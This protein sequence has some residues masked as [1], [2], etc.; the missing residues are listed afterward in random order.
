MLL[1]SKLQAPTGT[2]LRSLVRG[3]L[4]THQTE[5]SSPPT[6]KYYK[7]TLG[8]FLWYAERAAWPDDA[9]L[10]TEWQVREFLAYV[11]SGGK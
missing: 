1:D 10:L 9:R 4:L 6:V 5:G 2:S 11:A 3:F 8:R 7:G